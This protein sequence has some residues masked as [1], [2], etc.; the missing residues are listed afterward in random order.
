M[1]R[2]NPTRASFMSRNSSISN[3]N[4]METDSINNEIIAE[5][6]DFDSQQNDG[7]ELGQS[8]NRNSSFRKS[9]LR[10]HSK[11]STTSSHQKSAAPPPPING[12]DEGQ[13]HIAP[14][15]PFLNGNPFFDEDTTTAAGDDK[16]RQQLTQQQQRSYEVLSSI[17]LEESPSVADS[18]PTPKVSAKKEGIYDDYFLLLTCVHY[19]FGQQPNL[20]SQ[21]FSFQWHIILL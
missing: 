8:F 18:K 21:K 10:R 12:D 1:S 19:L 9:S 2:F 11:R 17:I 20:I 15:P 7:D 13:I 5:N 14:L 3:G 6:N 16:Q 4:K